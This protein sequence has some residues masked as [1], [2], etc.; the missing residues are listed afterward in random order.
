MKRAIY[1]MLFII[2][3]VAAG[4]AGNDPLIIYGNGFSFSVTE[5]GDWHCY[6]EDAYRYKL[7]AYFL[8][9]KAT[10]H[11]FLAIMHIRVESKDEDTVQKCLAYDMD[12]FSKQVK[13]I[14]FLE[15]DL[16]NLKY[17]YASK[18]YLMDDKIVDYVC[19]IDPYKESPMHLVFVLHGPKEESKKFEKDFA[20]LIKSFSWMTA[21]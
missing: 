11:D 1:L 20:S 5:P 17:E 14:E 3:G 10:V 15:F 12:K 7:N 6:T 18:I 4:Y 13:K 9:G 16:G 21:T 8:L 2:L 19:Y